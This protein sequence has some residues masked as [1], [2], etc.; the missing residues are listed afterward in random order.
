MSLEAA[1]SEPGVHASMASTTDA[2][3]SQSVSQMHAASAGQE[4]QKDLFENPFQVG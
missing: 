1:A 3:A 2:G 4:G